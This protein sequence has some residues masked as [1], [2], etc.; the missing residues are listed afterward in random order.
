MVGKPP[1]VPKIET[2]RQITWGRT[3][4]SAR[5]RRKRASADREGHE[6]H[7]CRRAAEEDVAFSR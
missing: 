4:S 7:S 2:S 3:H 5:E 1:E 6:F